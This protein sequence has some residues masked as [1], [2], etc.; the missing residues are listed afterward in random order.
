M[1]RRQ[2]RGVRVSAARTH[3]PGQKQPRRRRGAVVI[4]RRVEEKSRRCLGGT[5]VHATRSD[6]DPPVAVTGGVTLLLPVHTRP[7]SVANTA[8]CCAV[9]PYLQ[10]SI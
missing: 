5:G 4:V 7:V 6:P 3:S 8:H 10:N 1:Q 2:R 9:N